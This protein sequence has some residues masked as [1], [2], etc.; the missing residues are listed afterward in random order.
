LEVEKV[1]PVG[2]WPAEIEGPHGINVD[3]TGKYWYLSLG[4][5]FPNGTL[6]RFDA[7]SDTVVGWTELGL[8]PATLSLTPEGALA[9]I[10][11]ANFY[12]DMVPS[13]V[14]IVDTPTMMEIQ[15]TETCTMPHG[16]RMS[17]D[18][19]R[20]YSACMMDDQLVEISA[21]SLEVSR[22]MNM[23]TGER[24]AARAGHDMAGMAMGGA[25]GDP[26]AKKCSPTWTAP[27]A[28]GR[29]L[30]VACNKGNEI[31]EV[32]VRDW[33]VLRRLP[34]EGAPYNLA[35]THDGKRLLATLKGSA[36]L[37]VWDLTSGEQVAT[38]PSLLKVTHGVVV[39]ADDRFAI[40]TVE[41]VGGQPGVVEVIDLAT[42]QRVASAEVG[43]Q[44]GGIA[45]AVAR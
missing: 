13:T 3:P 22:R 16:S 23:V 32:D 4:H 7:A 25:A 34:A 11:N 14:S 27:A 42:Y 38:V 21:A 15:K 24:I 12:G 10:V 41:G 18:G 26:A 29:H 19:Q 44:A 5:G 28:D 20:N 37:A 31:V 2:R 17:P 33:K 6:L 1:I 35:L 43:K 36:H 30:Y 39:T 8:F 40:V 9:F 45:L